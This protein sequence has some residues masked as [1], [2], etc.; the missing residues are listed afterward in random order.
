M[1]ENLVQLG[2]VLPF[3][4]LGAG[5]I[6]GVPTPSGPGAS[7]RERVVGAPREPLTHLRPLELAIPQQWK[8]VPLGQTPAGRSSHR[9]GHCGPTRSSKR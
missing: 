2:I 7:K 1:R 3:Q 5:I 6:R 4:M 9:T 8:K